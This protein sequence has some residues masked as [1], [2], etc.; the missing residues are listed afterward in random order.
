MIST[1]TILR[2]LAVAPAAAIANVIR[3]DKDFDYNAV[4]YREVGARNTLVS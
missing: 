3:A 1:S 2:L 4:S